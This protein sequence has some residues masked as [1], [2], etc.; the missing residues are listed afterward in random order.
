MTDPWDPRLTE[1]RNPRTERIDRAD[2]LDIV[3]LVQA[4]DRRVPAA[5][6]AEAER[7]AALIDR[8]VER[9]R[10]GGRLFYVGAGTS[11]RLGALDAA[12]CPP[13]FGTDPTLVQAIIAGGPGALTRSREGAEDDRA[14]GRRAIAE[15][16]VGGRDFVLGIATSGTTPFVHAAL[17]EAAVR[18]AGI[19]FLSC[20]E[21]PERVR[22]LADVL[23]TPLVGPEVIAGSTRLKAGTATKLV[24]NTLTTGAM[25]RLGKVYGNLM[26]DLRATSRK[27]ADRGLRILE[28]VAGLGRDEARRLLERA[29]GSV[30]TALAMHGLGEGRAV[31]ERLLDTVGGRLAEALDRYREGPRPLYAGYPAAPPT[32]AEA[33]WLRER[34]TAGP[35]RVGAAVEEATAGAARGPGT[36]RGAGGW[37]PAEH[38]AH[39]L[40]FELEGVEP[41]VRRWLEEAGPRFS[42]L[43]PSDPPPRA[44]EAAATLLEAW[45]AA[46]RRSVAALEGRP[47]AD[48]RRAG[49]IGEERVTL[50]QFLRG[51][52]QHDDAHAR[53]IEEWAAR[54]PLSGG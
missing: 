17:E 6:E 53:R 23:V 31:A 14:A 10:S 13:T 28:H 4:E 2:T 37:T 3:R 33:A 8:V 32:E 24:L 19:G 35:R 5:V 18:G 54:S 30:K 46:R 20:T 43:A 21:P 7:I 51:V 42:G 47:P 34:L 12:E 36:G 27:L 49:R 44:G 38:V 45:A 11:G 15:R 9:L 39:L 22:G 40:E 29:G 26:V 41:R 48:L 16:D 25:I 52:A 50:G 1:A